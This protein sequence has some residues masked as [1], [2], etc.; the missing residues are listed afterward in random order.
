MVPN[1]NGEPVAISTALGGVLTTAVAFAAL[2]L[3]NQLTKEMQLAI[4]ALGNA[5]IL[6]A[7]VV[8]G[9]AKSTP[10]ANPTLPAGTVVNVE[11]PVGQPNEQ[12]TV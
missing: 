3:P 5:L 2:L 12:V 11:T 10:V 6:T 9:R 4:I 7:V 8:Y 1:V